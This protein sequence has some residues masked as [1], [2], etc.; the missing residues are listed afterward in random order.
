MNSFK[1]LDT[2]TQVF[3]LTRDTELIPK[4]PGTIPSLIPPPRRLDRPEKEGEGGI[5]EPKMDKINNP[6]GQFENDIY[7]DCTNSTIH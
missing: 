3:R 2:T 6:R 4:N 1:T 5:F 7:H